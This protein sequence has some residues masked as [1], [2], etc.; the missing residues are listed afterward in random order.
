MNGN[1][2]LLLN[3][4]PLGD[5][6]CTVTMGSDWLAAISPELTDIVAPGMHGSIDPGGMLRQTSRP[7][8]V[9]VAC[10]GSDA[11]HREVSRL[12][13]L[14]QMPDLTL[15][16][17]FDDVTQTAKVRCTSLASDGDPVYG[18]VQRL[19]IVFRIMGVWWRSPDLMIRSTPLTGG[20]LLPAMRSFSSSG[21]DPGYRTMWLGEP[22]SSPSILFDAI[23]EGMFADAPI[24]DPILRVPAGVTSVTVT[25]PM[26]STGVMWNGAR[27]DAQP[28]LYLDP[29]NLKAWT[30]A[31]DSA[32]GGGVDATSGLDY[33][34]SGPLALTPGTDGGYAVDSRCTGGAQDSSISFRFHRSWW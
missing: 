32:W 29:A 18:L 4:V 5:D 3:S 30:S 27:T 11:F 20:M 14:T 34:A 23:P 1:Y 28:F 6:D 7:Y 2:E 26:S 12:T 9:K 22:D 10:T 16:R 19:T 33:P 21:D 13:R 17:V 25:D 24:T 8:T 31:S 15:T